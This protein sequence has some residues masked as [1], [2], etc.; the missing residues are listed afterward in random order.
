[1]TNTLIIIPAFNEEKTIRDIVQRCQLAV[2]D[3]LV[4]VVDD[5][6]TDDTFTSA[7]KAGAIVRRHQQNFGYSQALRTG[8]AYALLHDFRNVLQLDADSQHP[9]E[10]LPTILSTMEN[11]GA[12]VVIGSRFMGEHYKIPVCRLLGMKLFRGL[13]ER[14]F[15]LVVTDT[16]SGLRGYSR[17]AITYVYHHHWKYPDACLLAELHRIGF[18][19]REI[20]VKMQAAE[21]KSMH[22]GIE[23]IYYVV[24]NLW[25]MIKMKLRRS[26]C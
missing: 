18:K 14:L 15:G 13:L 20:G 19:I 1:M 25:T 5:G 17:R 24:H 3:A 9:P 11:Y 26:A 6:S 16:T 23:P 22:G 2:P 12:D 7:A 8:Y 21:G 4:L 10:F